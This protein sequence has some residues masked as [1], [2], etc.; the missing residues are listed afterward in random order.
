MVK[1]LSG[2]HE[3][4]K[5]LAFAIQARENLILFSGLHE[6]LFNFQ[7]RFRKEAA[8]HPLLPAGT[9]PTTRLLQFNKNNGLSESNKLGKQPNNSQSKAWPWGMN[10][11]I[12]INLNASPSR[13]PNKGYCQLCEQQDQIAKQCPSCKYMFWTYQLCSR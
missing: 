4:Y 11:S 1:I 10:S 9:N 13:R 6:K 8:K 2:L 5:D 12:V 3:E 7:A